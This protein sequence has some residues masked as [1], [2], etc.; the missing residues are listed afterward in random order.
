MSTKTEMITPLESF[1]KGHD[2]GAW[3]AALKELLPSIHEVDRNATEIWF[4]FYPL[5]LLRAFERA[6]DPEE[7]AQKLLMQGP[8]LLK[9]QIDSSHVFLYG[10]RYWPEVKKHV[11][12]LV[13]ADG[14]AATPLLPELIREAAGKVAARLGVEPSLLVGITAVAF[15]TLTQVGLAAFEATP[16]T[17][18]I[19][20]KHRR[21]SPEQV[22]R[23]RAKDDGQGLLSFLRTTDKRW[24][25][26]WDENDEERR[27]KILDRQEL[28][29]GAAEDKR[30]WHELDPRC[31]VD[32]GPIPVQ[33]RSASC[34]TCWVGVLGGAE[35]LSEVSPRERRMLAEFGYAETDEPRPLI[36]LSC[37]AQGTG[38]VS[39][40][41][42]PWNGFY[43]KYLKK[44][45]EA[46]ARPE[47]EAVA[48]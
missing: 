8:Y 34:G 5:E 44:Q 14:V 12:T 30:P 43:G 26:V 33:C 40:V 7:L 47:G 13:E 4:H 27:F 25:V 1:L 38:A 6:E 9:N 32:E 48:G 35:K 39:I 41:I 45:R 42:P 15:M 46:A 28:A 24:T 23:E 10:H 3:R 11:V 16:G 17:V 20:E 22:L 18:L 29:S 19:D 31:T 36:R 37:Q 21:K 2:A